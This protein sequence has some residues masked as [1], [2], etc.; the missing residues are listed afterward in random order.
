MTILLTRVTHMNVR[1]Y[2]N[3]SQEALQLQR[4]QTVWCCLCERGRCCCCLALCAWLQVISLL[5]TLSARLPDIVH[6]LQPNFDDSAVIL[7]RDGF[8]HVSEK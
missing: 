5:S 2:D 6:I 4:R 1:G 7:I 3:L 8:A